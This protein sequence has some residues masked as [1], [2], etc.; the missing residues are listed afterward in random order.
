MC[1]SFLMKA[2]K[3]S[4]LSYGSDFFSALNF[5]IPL[6]RA[7]SSD[8]LH[9]LWNNGFFSD[10]SGSASLLFFDFLVTVGSVPLTSSTALFLVDLTREAE[11]ATALSLSSGGSGFAPD[12]VWGFLAAAGGGE[13]LRIGSG[14]DSISSDEESSVSSSPEEVS[15][16][17]GFSG[18][19]D[20]DI[21]LVRKL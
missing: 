11:A 14:S 4:I 17:T 3:A 13:D 18:S 9:I 21:F 16:E 8:S 10:A 7:I 19:R 2:R 12:G 20:F 1:K 5:I 15:E 6:R